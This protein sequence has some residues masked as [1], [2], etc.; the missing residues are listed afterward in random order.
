M[1]DAEHQ[2]EGL[3]ETVPRREVAESVSPLH[4]GELLL[5]R[6]KLV[7]LVG[8]GGMGEVYEARDL[9][10]HTTVALKTVR[11]SAASVESLLERLRREVQLA[12]GV[13]HPNVCRLFD[14]HEGPGPE[15][16]PVAFVTMEF[17]N[18]ETLAERLR[19]GGPFAPRDALPLLEQMAEGLA[20]IHAR[21]LVH[22][23]FKPGN[24]M[25]VPCREPAP[26]GGHGFGDCPGRR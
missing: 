3:G 17:L 22:R 26:C 18:G 6:F 4:E 5:D 15:G 16:K 14:F 13:T 23:D 7:R 2:T 8:Q 20:S 25:L 1:N 12:R 10:L 11:T 19:A 24:V 9:R 21:R